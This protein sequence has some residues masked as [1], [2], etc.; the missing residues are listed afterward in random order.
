MD[1]LPD[2]LW[3][4]LKME[5]QWL[6]GQAAE[7]VKD[8]A[9]G[10]F[11]WAMRGIWDA[12]MSLLKAAF[13]LAD[14]LS[15]FSITEESDPTY[16]TWP[17][18]LWI[19]G[20]VALGLFF[21]QLTMTA[22]RGGRGFVRLVGGPAQ[23]GIALGVTVGLVAAL[24]VAAD[25]LTRALLDV[26]MDADN[27]KDAFKS[28]HFSADAVKGLKAV[29]LGLCALLGVL[30]AAFGYV[31]E[32]L[33]REAAIHLLI[34]AV[35]ITAA[36]LTAAVTSR[37][38]W[39]TIRW[40]LAAVLMKPVLA[41]TLALGVGIAGKTKGVTG[42]LVGTAVLLIS[43]LAP[44]VLFR[45]LSFVDPHTDTGSAFRNALG[46][47]GLASTGIGALAGSHPF[48]SSSGSSGSPSSGGGN[49]DGAGS[50]DDLAESKTTQR[51][52]DAADSHSPGPDQAGDRGG[53]FPGGSARSDHGGSH[54]HPGDDDPDAVT[55][56]G[57]YEIS[58]VAD[59]GD[60]ATGGAPDDHGAGGSAARP[61]GWAD[62]PLPPDPGEVE[63]S[64]PPPDDAET[65][66][67]R[68]YGPGGEFDDGSVI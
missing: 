29:L 12:S 46:A 18:T 57:S 56:D 45:F 37:W 40:I 4:M 52:D 14:K 25:E 3:E 51:F 65:D 41:L 22:L 31:L 36:G 24:L 15:V 61:D 64:A 8:V 50:G 11:E 49:S 17:I 33:F 39:T 27:F 2:L 19:S 28:T 9:V 63:R 6:A 7:G 16:A 1:Q 26:G 30:P 35:P 20:L 32:M 68:P 47:T 54:G 48:S 66:R 62:V 34:A 5:G 44:I 58:A 42:V 60:D 13:G 55:D 23:Y 21:W 67:E 43:L 59:T 38:Y 10:A 53:G